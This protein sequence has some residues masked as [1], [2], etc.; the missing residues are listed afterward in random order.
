MK[1]TLRRRHTG[2]PHALRRLYA[3]DGGKRDASTDPEPTEPVTPRAPRLPKEH[4]HRRRR[5]LAAVWISAVV[6]A[7]GLL[8]LLVLP[9]RAWLAQR[10]DIASAEQKLSVIETENVKLQARLKALQTPEEIERVAREQYN[11]SS[12]GE[13]VFSVLPAPALTNLPTGWP[14]A[15]VNE[16]VAVQTATAAAATTTAPAAPPATDVPTTAAPVATTAAPTSS[17]SDG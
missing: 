16:I 10:N 5:I 9:T 8:L 7:A 12:D 14:Y 15:L 4:P 13:Q 3:L 6:T 2:E 1:L 11:L 17:S